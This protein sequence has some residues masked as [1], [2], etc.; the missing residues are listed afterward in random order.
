MPEQKINLNINPTEILE[1]LLS[2]TFMNSVYLKQLQPTNN[3]KSINELL[4]EVVE[5]WANASSVVTK[6]V[7]S[8]GK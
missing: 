2:A 5:E 4:L 8:G 1:P 6:A 3:N 7:Q